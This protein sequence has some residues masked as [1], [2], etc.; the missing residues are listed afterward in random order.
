[1][2]SVPADELAAL[3][4]EPIDLLQ[5]VNAGAFELGWRLGE[6]V[7]LAHRALP[8]G[9]RTGSSATWPGE[10]DPEA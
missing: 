10:R 2:R 9:R 8:V 3:R 6:A 5:A 1:M 7:T 4:Q